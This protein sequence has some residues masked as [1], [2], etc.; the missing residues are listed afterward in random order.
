MLTTIGLEV[1]CQLKTKTKIFCGCS[2]SFGQ[3][4]NSFVCPVCLGLPGALP[5]LNREAFLL[6]LRAVL[7]THGT[8]SKRIKF[9]RKNYFYP[10]LPKGYQISQFGAPIGQGGVIEIEGDGQPKKVRLNRIHME[11][12]AGKLMHDQTP[13]SSVVDLNRAG[14]PLIEIVTEPD[15]ESS[16]E[17]YEYLTD[18]KA[19]LKTIG[20]SDC[21]MEKGHLRC[22]ANVSVRKDAADKLGTRVE[23]KNLNSFKAVK[24]AI[25]YEVARQTEVLEKNEKIAQ[26]TRLWDDA[27]SKTFTMRSKEEAHD[28]RYF[29]EPDLVPFSVNEAEIDA[30]KKLIPELPK[31]KK[32][33]YEKEY[34]L[35]AYDAKL[36]TQDAVFSLFFEECVAREKNYKTIAN[37]MLGA[38]SAYLNERNQSLD[39]TKL[40][41]ALL[42]SIISL[43]LSGKVSL[44]TAK[45]KIFPDVIENGRKPEEVMKERG[46]EQVS[47]DSALN[48]WIKE[49]VGANP[50]VV[51]DFKSGKESSAMFL[52]GQVMKK[53]QGKA[54]PG[55]VQELVKKHLKEL[56]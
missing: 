49:V 5:V 44:Q 51:D 12:D 1:H 17:A 29:P 6:A 40:T 20:V 28:Y 14:T 10:D 31:D 56:V 19:I 37:W 4:P 55:K 3:A 18:L 34:G 35:S 32:A 43:T 41:P 33:R 30:Q 47:D 16:D 54:N 7:A 9:D 42:I 8:V 22:D 46:L 25:E 36:L 2:L 27:R 50:K 45:E 26:E 38:V 48:G 23:I 13:D 15:M 52:V 24:S 21:D 39:E 11:E 53:S